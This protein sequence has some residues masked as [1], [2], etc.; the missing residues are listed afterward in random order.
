[1]YAAASGNS[2][3]PAAPTG[4]GQDAYFAIC[5]VAKDQHADIREWVEYH[6]YIGTSKIYIFDHASKPPMIQILQ[7]YVN[8]GLVVYHYGSRYVKG[9]GWAP[10]PQKHGYNE[11]LRRYR[12]LHRWLAFIDADE[13]I[14]LVNNTQ[15]NIENFLKGYESYG[16]LGLNWV[17]FGSSNHTLRPPNG[18]LVN[19]VHSLELDR[20][21]HKHIKTVANTL[22]I[23][24]VAGAHHSGY[25]REDKFTVTEN[26]ERID[27]P[28]SPFPSHRKIVLLHYFL[29]SRQDFAAKIQRGAGGGGKKT[30][31]QFEVYDSKATN[32][33]EWAVQIGK[34]CCNSSFTYDTLDF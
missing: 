21:V 6:R 9:Q 20:P 3:L 22:Y 13:F 34:V 28:F 25:R 10:S 1:M 2:V 12:H 8:S 5:L 18:V 17:M 4:V 16:G 30:M 7:D 14:Y 23:D 11:C 32:L 24:H 29:K 15:P 33:C 19:F 26:F 27:G 31:D